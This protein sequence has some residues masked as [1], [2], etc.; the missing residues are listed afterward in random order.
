M[1]DRVMAYFERTT[2]PNGGKPTRGFKIQCG[3]CGF[4]GAVPLNSSLSSENEAK[5]IQRKFEE[6][7]WK[8]GKIQTQHRCPRCFSAIKNAAIVKSQRKE[9]QVTQP[10]TQPREM[11]KEDKRLIFAKIHEVYGDNSYLDNWTDAKVAI[12]L[13]VPRAWVKQV[14]EAD[15]GAEGGNEEIKASIEEAKKILADCKKVGEMFAPLLGRAEKI[16]KTMIEIEKS[17]R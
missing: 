15:F 4:N 16:E 14:R 7:G 1:G 12:D 11:Q 2:V 13:G 10:Q 6:I 8:I 5:I 17:L 9:N 3:H